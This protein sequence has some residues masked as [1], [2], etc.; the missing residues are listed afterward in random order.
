M[1]HP[2][3]RDG[4]KLQTSEPYPINQ[5]PDDLLVKI[6]GYLVHLHWF[7]RT[8]CYRTVFMKKRTTDMPR[9]NTHG[10]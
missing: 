5:L 7:A 6:G 9:M 10:R 1:K 8:I 4:R 2:R 3:L